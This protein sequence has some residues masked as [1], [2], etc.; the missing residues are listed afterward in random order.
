MNLT[1]LLPRS[2]NLPVGL[3]ANA[4]ILRRASVQRPKLNRYHR[5]RI[6][7]AATA[8]NGWD[9]Y[10]HHLPTGSSRP[11]PLCT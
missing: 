2:L 4:T 3:R 6:I 10:H 11:L 1:G 5:Q 7:T 8:S 9:G